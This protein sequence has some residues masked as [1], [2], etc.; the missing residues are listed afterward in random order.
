[1]ITGH[2]GVAGVA[3]SLQRDRLSSAAF[4]ALLLASL[5]PD[6]LDALY[7]VARVCNP[8][9]LYSHT[10]YAAV[11]Q[12]AVIGGATLLITGS[13]AAALT[14]AIV[15]LLHVAGDYFTGQKLLLPGGELVGLR[16]YDR[17][18]L[19]FALEL[20]ILI[21]GWWILRRSGRAPRWAVSVRALA[22]L[23][24]L[25]SAFDVYGALHT[26]GIKPS[27]CFER[28]SSLSRTTLASTM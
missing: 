3:R 27:A 5:A 15:V 2:L 9:G 25:Q 21:G 10:V 7:A 17:P 16:W 6:V 4:V 22:L 1:V 19:D 13:R 14:F 18:L 23:V 24:L 26:K 20:P 8:Y 28:I 12:A 11:L